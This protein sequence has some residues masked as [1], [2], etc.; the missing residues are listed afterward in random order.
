MNTRLSSLSVRPEIVVKSIS[1]ET[2]MAS[3]AAII[4]APWDE[5]R[6]S[7][8]NRVKQSFSSRLPPSGWVFHLIDPRSDVEWTLF[9]R[10][11]VC[12]AMG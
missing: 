11:A 12:L 10:D 3:K 1:K 4:G 5:S 6:K 8:F 9:E 7:I 2:N